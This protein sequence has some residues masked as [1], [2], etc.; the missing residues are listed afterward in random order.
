MKKT[1][2][3]IITL[4]FILTSA[5]GILPAYA[6]ESPDE[7]SADFEISTYLE[8]ESIKMFSTMGNE[9]SPEATITADVISDSEKLNTYK[10]GLG[11]N[12]NKITVYEI[13][14]T[15]NGQAVPPK[16]TFGITFVLPEGYDMEKTLVLL[17]AAEG[18]YDIMPC[19]KSG[20]TSITTFSDCLGTFIVVE[21]TDP[22]TLTD[23]HSTYV[24]G[25][26]SVTPAP[27]QEVAKD[28]NV[29]DKGLSVWL[30]VGIVA[31]VLAAVG[32]IG[33]F[34]YGKKKKA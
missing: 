27:T 17:S 2:T 26:E 32:I 20:D 7:P 11:K 34:V 25:V 9:F 33:Y 22:I 5:V 19:R 21:T 15:E 18:Q 10:E 28:D 14:A 4:L 8:T 30:I 3:L 23:L 24:W 13:T 6:A 31:A 1:K 16:G 12:A 29:S